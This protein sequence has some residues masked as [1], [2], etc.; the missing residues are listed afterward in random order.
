KLYGGAP[1]KVEAYN[2]DQKIKLATGTL[3]T[4]DNQID[5]TTGTVRL[6]AKFENSDGLLFANQFVNA[7]LLLDVKKDA[8]LVPTIALQRGTQGSFVY[9]V[10]DDH[11]VTVRPVTIGTQQGDDAAVDTGLTPGEMV[12]VDGADKL[13]DGAKVE[14]QTKDAAPGA[15]KR[16]STS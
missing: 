10:K 13:R 16:R 2:R 11:T 5:P 14:I 9:V 6:K 12:V 8:T 3:L 15:G 7:R 4:V 1:L